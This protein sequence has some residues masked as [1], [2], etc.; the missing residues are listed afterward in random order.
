MRL[1]NLGVNDTPLRNTCAHSHLAVSAGD[2]RS[3]LDA[4]AAVRELD[5]DA[6]TL[7]SAGNGFLDFCRTKGILSVLCNY[8]ATVESFIDIDALMRFCFG[9]VNNDL[10]CEERKLQAFS[11]FDGNV[12]SRMY[13]VRFVTTRVSAYGTLV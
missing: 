5:F 7:T 13:E 2:L 3:L 12:I 9:P 6:V 4:F 10:E 11:I 8:R 1:G